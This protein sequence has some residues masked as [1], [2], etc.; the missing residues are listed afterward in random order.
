MAHQRI[1]TNPRRPLYAFVPVEL[2]DAVAARARAEQVPQRAVVE[3]ALRA[4]L[5]QD[6]ER[7]DASQPALASQDD[8]NARSGR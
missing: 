8:L 6:P 3:Q 1:F 5:G 4:L 2:A 7:Q